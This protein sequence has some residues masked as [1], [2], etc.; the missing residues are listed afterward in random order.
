MAAWFPAVGGYRSSWKI[1]DCENGVKHQ[2]TEGVSLSV[3]MKKKKSGGMFNSDLFSWYEH[4]QRLH[5][6]FDNNET[7]KSE[8]FTSA[9]VQTALWHHT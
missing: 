8:D 5:Q 1:P 2:P 9:D 7:V 3:N 4:R 6:V